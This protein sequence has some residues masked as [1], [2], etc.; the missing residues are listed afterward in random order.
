M[1]EG[2]ALWV[3]CGL[4][5]L[6]VPALHPHGQHMPPDTFSPVG[7]G[8]GRPVPGAAAAL[9]LLHTGRLSAA[10]TSTAPAPTAAAA[11]LSTAA[12]PAG[13]HQPPHWWPSDAQCQP[14]SGAAA[15]PTCGH[16][17]VLSSPVPLRQHR[18]ASD[19]DRHLFGKPGTSQGTW[20]R[21]TGGNS[22]GRGFRMEARAV[23]GPP[24][25]EVVA[26]L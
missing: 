8:H 5:C 14:D 7:G 3:P 19:G 17:T 11:R 6:P 26:S 18:P 24:Q 21:A 4:A 20:L 10:T 22:R 15:A 23:P 1:P 25:S 9:R 13:A 16:S 12:T 2:R